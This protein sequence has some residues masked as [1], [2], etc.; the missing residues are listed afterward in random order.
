MFVP[1]TVI[2]ITSKL[3]NHEHSEM[4]KLIQF[5]YSFEKSPR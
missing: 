4:A 2:P 3:Q 5:Y 1:P